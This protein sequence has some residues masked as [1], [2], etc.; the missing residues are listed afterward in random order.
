MLSAVLTDVV[1]ITRRLTLSTASRDVLNNPSFGNPE[2]WNFVY[3]N[4][5][6][7]IA[8]SGKPLAFNDKGELV[9]PSGTLYIPKH[10]IIK[11]MDRIITVKCPGYAAGI[12]YVVTEIIPS[13]YGHGLLDHWEG[14][15][16]LPI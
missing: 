4:I 5:R 1:N 14:K 12:E 3:T 7:R 6:L 2:D 9:R 8:F 16:E 15:I 13:F 10:I 11:P